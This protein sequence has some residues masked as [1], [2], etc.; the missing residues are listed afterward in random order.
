MKEYTFQYT[1]QSYLLRLTLITIFTFVLL[2]I[3]VFANKALV[4]IFPGLIVAVITPVAIFWFNRKGVTKTGNAVI[5]SSYGEFNLSGSSK[6]ISFDSIRRYKVER[7][8]GVLLTVKLNDGEKI[9][10]YANPSYCDPNPLNVLASKF[11]SVVKQHN[12]AINV[13]SAESK[14][15]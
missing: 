15:S 9:S 14:A 6:K 2:L 12:I 5:A 10:I 3:T 1:D 13:D 11:E 8:R 7:Y 4:G